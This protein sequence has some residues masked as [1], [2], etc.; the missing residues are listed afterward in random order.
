MELDKT[1]DLQKQPGMLRPQQALNAFLTPISGQV[2]AMP[3]DWMALE[4]RLP[5]T[6]QVSARSLTPHVA[7]GDGP[8]WRLWNT[9]TGAYTGALRDSSTANSRNTFFTSSHLRRIS[10]ETGAQAP[11]MALTGHLYAGSRWHGRQPLG[12]RC[13]RTS[14]GRMGRTAQAAMPVACRRNHV[15]C[16]AERQLSLPKQVRGQAILWGGSG[17]HRICCMIQARA[18][19]C[20]CRSKASMDSAAAAQAAKI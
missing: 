4:P 10:R 5:P 16:S 2:L 3:L 7:G 18:S 19:W 6:R 8:R 1:S 13:S 20:S 12:A 11:I 17:P 9:Y 14:L 15:S